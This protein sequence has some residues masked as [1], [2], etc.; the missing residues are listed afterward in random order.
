MKKSNFIY[1]FV[2]LLSVGFIACNETEIGNEQLQEISFSEVSEL[3]MDLLDSVGFASGYFTLEANGE[4]LVSSDQMTWVTFSKSLDGEYYADVAGNKGSDTVYVKISNNGRGYNGDKANIKLIANGEEYVVST[5]ER[6]G[7]K[8]LNITDSNG[9]TV[10]AVEIGYSATGWFSFK[11][12]FDCGIIE[13]L[14]WLEEPVF[15]ND[16]YRFSVV[17]DEELLQNPQEGVLLV[18]D[19]TK[20]LQCNI[21]VKYIGMDPTVMEITGDSPWNW[22]ASIDGKELKSKQTLDSV[23][24]KAN[25]E[26]NVVCRNNAYSIIFAEEVDSVLYPKNADEAW[27]K[28]VCDE[29]NPKAVTVTVDA[30]ESGASRSGYLF[31]VPEAVCDSFNLSLA[32]SDSTNVFVDKYQK[33]VLAQIEQRDGGFD[34][35]RVDESGETRIQCEI[36]ES[37]DYYIIVASNFFSGTAPDVSACNVE[38][39]KSY[40]INTKLTEAEWSPTN[41]ALFDINGEEIRIKTWIPEK[42][43]VL[44]DDGYYRINIT[45]PEDASWFEENEI[46]KDVVLRLYTP[47][48]VNIKAL[49]LRVQE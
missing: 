17:A 24:I 20:T 3:D 19:I 11:A 33:Y 6:P 18:S 32:L 27:I 22:L 47:D 45:V 8:W 1:L 9:A 13:W 16:G 21:P 26:M 28:G 5:V 44:G 25:L 42:K 34:V 4:W 14:E 39:G 15:E 31:A 35:Y 7:K 36:D 48:I 2:A 49:V 23:V 29:N 37:A 43:G 46:D 12:P 30:A 38:L 40:V 41:F 10:E